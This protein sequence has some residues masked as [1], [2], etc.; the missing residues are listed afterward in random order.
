MMLRMIIGEVF[1]VATVM[2][3][4]FFIISRISFNKKRA[5]KKPKQPQ[6]KIDGNS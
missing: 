2:V 3:G 4:I 5:V 6:E 1:I